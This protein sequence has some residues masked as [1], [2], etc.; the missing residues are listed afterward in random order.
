M[1]YLLPSPRRDEVG[2]M[3]CQTSPFC[4]LLS[5]LGD[6]DDFGRRRSPG[7]LAKTLE[8]SLEVDD[9]QICTEDEWGIRDAISPC[10]DSVCWQY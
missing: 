10:D 6:D 5:S 3:S 7:H 8:D 9:D 1:Q 2:G 4:G